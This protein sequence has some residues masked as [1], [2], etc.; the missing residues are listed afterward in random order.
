MRLLILL[1]LGVWW[2][3]KGQ[4][5]LNPKLDDENLR[6]R[7]LNEY[8]FLDYI[9]LHAEIEKVERSII[10]VPYIVGDS[11][12]IKD[13]L[14]IMNHYNDSTIIFDLDEGSYVPPGYKI[15]L[16]EEIGDMDFVE[17]N[18]IEIRKGFVLREYL[19][20]YFF[21]ENIQTR[22]QLY[23]NLKIEGEKI[24]KY[25]AKKYDISTV[26]LLTII[27]NARYSLRNKR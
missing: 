2:T 13:T 27:D 9:Q 7:I 24:K 5:Q 1:T 19:Q 6:E 20:D 23:K 4:G 18:N 21:P 14:I 26:D 3:A 15:K 17:C 22:G 12:T 16:I 11:F 8:L 25:I 10:P